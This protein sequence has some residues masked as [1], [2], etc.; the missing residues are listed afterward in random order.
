MIKN[1]TPFKGFLYAGLIIEKHSGRPYL[2]EFNARMGDPECQPLMMRMESDLFDYINAAEQQS[3]DSMAKIKWKNKFSICV[4]MASKGYPN[5]FEIGY[6]IQGL[7][8]IDR[9]DLMVFH[10][11]TKLNHS[12]ELVTNG[13]RVLSVTSLGNSSK[14]AIDKVYSNV[15]KIFWGKNQQQFRRDI[16]KK[17]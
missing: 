15:E 12:N 13:G 1:N 4:V 8:K 17:A 14:D 16:A 3:L 2:L 10:S 7:D 9:E 11:G 5:K 6:A